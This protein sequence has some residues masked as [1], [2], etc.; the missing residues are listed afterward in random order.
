[1]AVLAL[2]PEVYEAGFVATCQ[3]QSLGA[4]PDLGDADDAER[5]PHLAFSFACAPPGGA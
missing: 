3:I 2:A 1:M 5:T 4:G